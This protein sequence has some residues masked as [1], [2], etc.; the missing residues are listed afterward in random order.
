MSN[1]VLRGRVAWAAHHTGLIRVCLAR[2]SRQRRNERAFWVDDETERLSLFFRQS[3][4]L[5]QLFRQHDSILFPFPRDEDELEELHRWPDDGNEFERCFEDDS[6]A[7]IEVGQMQEGPAIEPIAVDLFW[8]SVLEREQPR[9]EN[10][11]PDDSP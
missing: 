6:D 4:H 5:Q 3:A 11:R 1:G 8:M 2:R 7:A 10:G 9:R